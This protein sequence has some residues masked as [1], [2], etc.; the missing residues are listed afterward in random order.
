MGDCTVTTIYNGLR[1]DIGSAIAP[2]TTADDMRWYARVGYDLSYFIVISTILM[3]VIFG[4]I[5]DTFGSLRDSTQEREEDAKNTCFI[6]CLDRT[7][8]DKVANSKDIADGFNYLE[9]NNGKQ[10]RWNYLNF[11][12]YLKRKDTTE[13]TGPETKI[14][15]LLLDADT[16]WLPLNRCKLFEDGVEEEAPE[17]PKMDVSTFR[18]AIK[19]MEEKLEA[20]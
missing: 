8:V 14:H 12:F 10:N 1:M 20:A 5:I 3:N 19:R 18:A 4:I 17:E 13:Y 16:S 11:V 2:V 9:G 7:E 6:S 15:E